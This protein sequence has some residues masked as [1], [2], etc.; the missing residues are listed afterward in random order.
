MVELAK[1]SN[2][3]AYLLKPC[4]D[5]ELLATISLSLSRKD[6]EK[7]SRDRHIIQLKNN[8]HFDTQTSILYKNGIQIPLTH[9]KTKLIEILAIHVDTI[10]SHEHI[11]NYIWKEPRE[12]STLRSLIYRTKKAIKED[13]ITNINGVG[14]SINGK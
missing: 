13:L 9:T 5:E 4:M 7:K 12:I 11:C 3:C 2:A 8:F 1:K 10:L 6:K 14:Y